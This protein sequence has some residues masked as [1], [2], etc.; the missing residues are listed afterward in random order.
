MRFNDRDFGA[1]G[2]K[3][4]EKKSFTP[5]CLF[6]VRNQSRL[7]LFVTTYSNVKS[8]LVVCCAK[9]TRRGMNFRVRLQKNH[10]EEWTTF[11]FQKA[12]LWNSRPWFI[13]SICLFFVRN[14]SR[15]LLFVT[16][17]SNVQSSLVVWCAKVTRRRSELSEQ[18]SPRSLASWAPPD[19]HCT[20]GPNPF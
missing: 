20:M 11:I 10:S 13:F 15:L 18:L 6:F 12:W 2:Q 3:A 16:T 4:E 14:Q 1:R 17:Y 9:V 7:L 8:S 19:S 5:I